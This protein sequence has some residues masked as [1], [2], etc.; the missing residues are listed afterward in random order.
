[1]NGE[2]TGEDISKTVRGDIY[3]GTFLKVEMYGKG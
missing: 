2:R 3:G 1:M